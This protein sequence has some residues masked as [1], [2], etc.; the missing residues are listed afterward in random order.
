MLTWEMIFFKI[1]A[2]GQNQNKNWD[3]YYSLYN[4]KNG[5]A[6]S[7]FLSNLQEFIIRRNLGYLIGKLPEE[8]QAFYYPIP[9]SKGVYLLDRITLIKKTI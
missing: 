7:Y 4:I 5:L 9:Q 8:L 2:I 6:F 3:P 1:M